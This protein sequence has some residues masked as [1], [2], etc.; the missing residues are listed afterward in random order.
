MD[1]GGSTSGMGDFGTSGS[2]S[3]T[4]DTVEAIGGMVD[5][6]VSNWYELEGERRQAYADDPCRWL[7]DVIQWEQGLGGIG[8]VIRRVENKAVQLSTEGARAVEAA[9][10]DL[11]EPAPNV[12]GSTRFSDYLEERSIFDLSAARAAIGPEPIAQLA[13]TG[14]R[15][16]IVDRLDPAVTGDA[17]RPVAPAATNKGL[18]L[19]PSKQVYVYNGPTSIS[20]TADPLGFAAHHLNGRLVGGDLRR[21]FW[22]WRNLVKREAAPGHIPDWRAQLT[23]LVGRPME[24]HKFS[25]DWFRL[26]KPGV[27]PEDGSELDTTRRMWHGVQEAKAEMQERCDRMGLGSTSTPGYGIDPTDLD[28]EDDSSRLGVIALILGALY[29]ANE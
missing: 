20:E 7:V 10:T 19:N 6:A 28:S 2:S 9:L 21:V 5:D 4:G 25:Q 17:Y 22:Q 24:V 1:P 13:L 15:N 23:K 14:I 11:G 29:L 8:N 3:S 16:N 12:T 27:S 18:Q 26:W